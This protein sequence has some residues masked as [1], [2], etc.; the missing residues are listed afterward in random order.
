MRVGVGQP[1]L[2]VLLGGGGR[3]LARVHRRLH[4]VL[5]VGA[6]GHWT[7]GLLCLLVSLAEGAS[8]L[9]PVVVL[10][11]LLLLLDERLLVLLNP[12]VRVRLARLLQA[13]RRHLLLVVVELRT[14]CLVYMICDCTICA[15]TILV[16]C[17]IVYVS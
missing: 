7:V 16:Q 5:L 3:Q 10:L 2:P 11:L 6:G 1:H 8:F 12:E 4:L 17:T 13:G 15:C 14:I 9:E